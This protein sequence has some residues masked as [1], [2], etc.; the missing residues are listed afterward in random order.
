[1]FSLSLYCQR[2]SC[3]ALANQAKRKLPA[4]REPGLS[5]GGLGGLRFERTKFCA[6]SLGLAQDVE[7][8]LLDLHV[9]A[10]G[11]LTN[12]LLV[13]LY[14]RLF[15]QHLLGKEVAQTA[16]NHLVDNRFRFAFLQ[17]SRLQQLA[18]LGNHCRIE[19]FGSQR[20]GAHSHDVHGHVFGHNFTAAFDL[21]Q[22][23]SDRTAVMA[24]TA[25][26]TGQSSHAAHIELLANA[27]EQFSLLLTQRDLRIAR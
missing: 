17:S 16:I 15:E 27:I 6:N 21:Q 8:E 20:I 7:H 2:E 11:I 5:P 9:V 12:R 25:S 1:M 10:L 18:L 3:R 26:C 4:L 19:L 24:V 14:E 13:I 22:H 23:A